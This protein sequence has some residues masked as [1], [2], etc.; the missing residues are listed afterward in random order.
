M[1]TKIALIFI[2][3]FLSLM[4]KA[5]VSAYT[6]NSGEKLFIQQT[7]DLGADTALIKF[8]GAPQSTWQKK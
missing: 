7:P 8:E 2:C 1:K 6:G 3:S 5:Q 4:A